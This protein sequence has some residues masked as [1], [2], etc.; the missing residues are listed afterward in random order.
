MDILDINIMHSDVTD[1]M[2][3]RGCLAIWG[4]S[5][6]LWVTSTVYFSQCLM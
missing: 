5:V 1:C 3:F 6:N 4:G 2:G